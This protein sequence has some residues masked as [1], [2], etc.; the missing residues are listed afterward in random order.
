MKI[1]LNNYLNKKRK[2]LI[3]FGFLIIYGII[4]LALCYKINI[5]ED[6]T[7]TLNT[8][9]RS[10]AGVIRQSY[11]FEGQPPVYFV[12]LYLWRLL[13]PAIFFARLFSLLFIGL[14]A[15]VF[16]R[17][18]LLV[19]GKNCLKWMTLIFLLNPFTVWAG[20]DIRTYSLLIFLS[21]ISIYFFFRFYIENKSKHLY[22][23]LVS[24]IIGV[25][26][27]YFFT[28]L[29]A[30]LAFSLLVFNGW[31][32][33]WK[34]CLY[35][36]PVVL[37]FLPNLIFL[38]NQIEMHKSLSYSHFSLIKFF[39]VVHTPQNLMLAINLMPE[40]WLNRFIRLLFLFIIFYSYYKLY[41]ERLVQEVS[42]F[43]NYTIILFSVFVLL[44]L[45]SIGIYIT[46]I[47]YDD[48]YMVVV[49]PLFMLLYNVFKIF[50]PAN[51]RLMYAALSIYFAVLLMANYRHPVSTYDFKSV[52][53]YIKEIELPNEPILVYRPAIALPFNNYYTGRNEVVPIPFPVKFD[54][55]YLINIKDTFELKQLIENIKSPSKSYLL[56]SDTTV[57]ES[58]VNMNRKM[59]DDY[60][61]THYT[62]SLD[63]L[64]YGWSKEKPL[65]IMRFEK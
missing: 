12:L 57:Y 10:L 28:L 29:I 64:F 14:S 3:F 56:L 63:T 11:Y 8:T 15:Y 19:S 1:F 46:D 62:V 48:K 40:V 20:L 42:F 65:R 18:V 22:F 9:S 44:F 39:I 38:S 53:K 6:E 47:G 58:T 36:I 26:T 61:N 2:N 7:Y 54:S 16:Y 50:K 27:Q 60:I 23:F 13:C 59:I 55:S 35:L 4:L 33:F 17:L 21:T 31:K 45:F 5:S 30:A 24:C 51:R 32:L 49:F 52:A 34:F 25:Y 43:K 41:K 37:L